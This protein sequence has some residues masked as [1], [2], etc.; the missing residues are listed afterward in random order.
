MTRNP[1][2]EPGSA[3]ALDVSSEQDSATAPAPTP[4]VDAA[5]SGT[6][7]GESP[8]ARSARKRRRFRLQTYAVLAVAVLVYLIALGASNTRHVKVDW[9]FG[10]ASVALIWL[11]LFAVILGWLL[12][13]LVTQLFR[14]RT[15]APRAS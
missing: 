5:G 12:G 1:T 15:R 2:A 13:I 11:V 3:P 4:G 8:Q 10:H 7:G 9:V 6:P 14:W